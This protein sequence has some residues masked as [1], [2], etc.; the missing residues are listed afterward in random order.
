ME[1]MENQEELKAA[2][3]MDT[4]LDVVSALCGKI[5]GDRAFSN[6]FIPYV[7]FSSAVNMLRED[8]YPVKFSKELLFQK[9]VA[10]CGTEPDEADAEDEDADMASLEVFS[11]YLEAWKKD[12]SKATQ[13]LCRVLL[14]DDTFECSEDLAAALAT[15]AM[16]T[17][18]DF[19]YDQVLP[20]YIAERTAPNMGW[21]KEKQRKEEMK[22]KG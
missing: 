3:E 22:C 1:I 11:P 9:L 12:I 21:I 7:L 17:L 16:D 8:G 13:E 20:A 4:L 6:E 14:M 10:I 5:A 18:L 15:N 19:G 2:A